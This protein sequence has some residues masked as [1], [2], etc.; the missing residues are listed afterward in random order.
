[1]LAWDDRYGWVQDEVARE[2]KHAE[3]LKYVR[4]NDAHALV[5]VCAAHGLGATRG[6]TADRQCYPLTDL[7]FD[8]DVDAAHTLNQIYG[9]LLQALDDVGTGGT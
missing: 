4:V 5:A 1:M 2:C 8:S 7:E 3:A 9:V 6:R